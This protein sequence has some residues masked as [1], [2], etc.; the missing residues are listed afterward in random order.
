LL[1]RDGR[2]TALGPAAQVLAS[3]RERLFSRLQA[4]GT[5]PEN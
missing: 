5:N 1:L 2:L 4:P 3:E